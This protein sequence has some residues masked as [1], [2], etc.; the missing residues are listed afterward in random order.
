MDKRGSG[1]ESTKN[2]FANP[3]DKN[4]DLFAKKANNTGTS[5]GLSNNGNT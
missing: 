4:N 2:A 3:S 1:N 5:L